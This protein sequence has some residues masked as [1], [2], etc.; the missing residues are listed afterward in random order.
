MSRRPYQIIVDG[1]DGPRGNGMLFHSR[2]IATHAARNL[3]AETGRTVRVIDSR[4]AG[5]HF[6]RA[7]TIASFTGGQD[8]APIDDH[9]RR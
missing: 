7:P 8:D 6:T 5:A 1:E 4:L 3:S 9:I 2:E